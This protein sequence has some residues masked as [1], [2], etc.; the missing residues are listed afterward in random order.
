[1]RFVIP[2]IVN[3]TIVQLEIGKG[4]VG[5]KKG[6]IK[7]KKRSKDKGRDFRWIDVNETLPETK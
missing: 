5:G 1:M 6:S 4:R 7:T 2:S 3:S